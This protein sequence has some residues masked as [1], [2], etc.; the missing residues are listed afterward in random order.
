MR[1]SFIVSVALGAFVY[2][3]TPP[4]FTPSIDTLLPASYG[5]LS[6]T[7]GL[8]IPE[9]GTFLFPCHSFVAYPCFSNTASASDRIRT[10]HSTTNYALCDYPHRSRRTLPRQQHHIPF[11]PLDHFLYQHLSRPIRGPA[12]SARFSAT[13]IHAPLVCASGKLYWGVRDAKRV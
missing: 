3:Q 2:A 7:P 8:H 13:S 5:N 12:A 1:T 10:Y 11:A 9:N 4:N 6:I